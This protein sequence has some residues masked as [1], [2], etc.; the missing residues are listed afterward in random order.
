MS[1]TNRENLYRVAIPVVITISQI[2]VKMS[3]VAGINL[4]LFPLSVQ[5]PWEL[6]GGE[7]LVKNDFKIKW[8][9]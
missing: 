5:L 1:Q 7:S 9:Q 2:G 6:L 3:E 8:L 4:T